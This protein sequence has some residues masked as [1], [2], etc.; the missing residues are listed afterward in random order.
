MNDWGRVIYR[1][2]QPPGRRFRKLRTP[3]CLIGKGKHCEREL[4]GENGKHRTESVVPGREQSGT[5]F[6]LPL[7]NS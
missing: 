6:V 2:F 1:I 3:T 7:S 4:K 5:L